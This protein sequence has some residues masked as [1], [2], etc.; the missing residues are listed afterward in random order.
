MYIHRYI[1][2]YVCV[3]TYIHIYKCYYP[4]YERHGGRL[5]SRLLVELGVVELMTAARITLFCQLH[6]LVVCLKT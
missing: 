5:R 3:H 2:M 6:L 4:T 1:Y